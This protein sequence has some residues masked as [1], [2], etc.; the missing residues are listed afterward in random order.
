MTQIGKERVMR[1][2]REN[3]GGKNLYLMTLSGNRRNIRWN[4]MCPRESLSIDL[5]LTSDLRDHRGSHQCSRSLPCFL[6]EEEL[7]QL[8]EGA[9]EC[10]KLPF[11]R[12]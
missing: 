9:S 7:L 10:P 6:L 3:K 5:S 4:R 11:P 8:L 2:R 1:Y 12:S